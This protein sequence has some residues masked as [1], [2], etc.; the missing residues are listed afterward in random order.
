LQV[1]DDG[2]KATRTLS[3]AWFTYD[4]SGLPFWLFG[5]GTFNIGATSVT[6][7]TVYLDGGKFAP[8][9]LQ[10]AVPHPS[11]GTVTFSFPDCGHMNIAYNGDASAVNGP[12]G[13]STATY[14][15]VADVNSLVC[16]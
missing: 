1:Y 13:N 3:F 8:S 6:A 16:Q 5:S 4:D 2:D 10:P 11:W 14:L 15:R 12:K 7:T 9:T